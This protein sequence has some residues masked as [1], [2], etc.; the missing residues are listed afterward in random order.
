VP[1]LR[2]G[3]GEFVRRTIGVAA[4]RRQHRDSRACSSIQF[5]FEPENAPLL[6][7]DARPK[8]LNLELQLADARRVVGPRK[9]WNQAHAQ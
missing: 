6:F 3:C 2:F 5:L 7:V 4:G 8:P 9:S 1:G